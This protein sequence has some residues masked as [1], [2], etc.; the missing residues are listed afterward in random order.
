MSKTI[1]TACL[2]LTLSTGAQ[3][4]PETTQPATPADAK[5]GEKPTVEAIVN[6]ANYVSYYQGDDGR[7]DVTMTIVEEQGMKRTREMT[8]LRSDAQADQ[9]DK[10]ATDKL[11]DQRYYVYFRRPNDMDKTSFLVWK[12]VEPGKDDD[13]WM[14]LP[15]LDLVRRISS[16]DKRTSFVGSD[17]FYEDVSGRNPTDDS[18]ELLADK[19]KGKFWVLKSTP[20]DP[21]SAE[22]AYYITYIHKETWMPIQT[23][24]YDKDN[25]KY[26]FYQVLDAFVYDDKNPDASKRRPTIRRSRMTDLKTKGY[27]ELNYSNVKYDVKLGKDIFEQRYLRQP[28]TEWLK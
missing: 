1:W 24:Y 5:A 17:Y 12:T 14:Y 21:K 2:L 3:A 20:K 13:R 22:F 7:A 16:S 15:S 4:Q 9:A 18:H 8:I 11:G 6:H 19:S 26:R 10:T 28:P 23:E 27:T 25:V